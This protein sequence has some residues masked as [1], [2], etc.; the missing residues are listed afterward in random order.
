MTALSISKKI[1][2]LENAMDKET[3]LGY[4]KSYIFASNQERA[5]ADMI[6]ARVKSGESVEDI[7]QDEGMRN[8]AQSHPLVQQMVDKLLQSSFNERLY[9]LQKTS[10][11]QLIYGLKEIISISQS[12]GRNVDHLVKILSTLVGGGKILGQ[13]GKPIKGWASGFQEK[14]A[15]VE[16]SRA[17]GYLKFIGEKGLES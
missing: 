15:L 13:E 11:Q 10:S 14:L 6:Q 17:L 12:S 2:D 16:N 1:S 8:Y 7:F 4:R 9:E 5:V 3:D